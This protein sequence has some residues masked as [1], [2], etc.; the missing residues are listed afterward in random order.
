MT[1]KHLIAA[2]A[3]VSVMLIA[4]GS[5]YLRGGS[6]PVDVDSAVRRF[7]TTPIEEAPPQV[8]SN[9]GR[10]Q[11]AAQAAKPNAVAK[12]AATR[13]TTTNE[14]LRRLTPYSR[15]AF[16]LQAMCIQP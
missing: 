1:R 5:L 4:I 16:R 3:A 15:C 9:T 11:A 6:T 12:T 7:R 14:P 2:I 13:S 10:P 8:N